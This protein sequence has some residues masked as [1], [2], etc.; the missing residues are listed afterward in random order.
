M[1]R[2]NLPLRVAG[3]TVLLSL[4][5]LGLCGAGA[6]YLYSQQATSADVLGENVSSAQAAHDLEIT[7]HGLAAL[8]PDNRRN[9]EGLNQLVINQITTAR[10]LADKEEERRL[11]G[12]LDEILH[13]Y[14]AFWKPGSRPTRAEAQSARDILDK[15]ALPICSKLEEFNAQQIKE[16]AA[17]HRATVRWMVAGLVGIGTV[18]SIGGLFLGY[19]VASSLRRSIYQLS[20]RVRD[21][22]GKL[23]QDLTPVVVTDDGDLHHL[24]NQVQGIMK[25]IEQVVAK[26]QQR[27]HEVLRAEQLAAVGQLAAG[28]AH[29]LRNPLTSVKILVQSLGE[30]LAGRGLSV[31]DLQIME[32]EIRRME[33]CLQAF[34]DF[35]R[36]PRPECRPLNLAQI[37]DRTFALIGSRARK[38]QVALKAA[39]PDFAV[40][41][42][43]D[44]DQI[45]Q[46]LVNLTLN[47]L[48]AMPHGGVLEVEVRPP[49]MGHVE[50][51]VRDTGPGIAA[52]VKDRLFA[53]FVSSK[54]TGLGLGLCTSRR[55]AEN[56][57]GTLDV[58]H[59]TQGGACFVLRLPVA[60][61]LAAPVAAA[62]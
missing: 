5:L 43:V 56:H 18:G 30:D 41:V 55:I 54:E 50:M 53:P 36:P 52:E 23:G 17:A 14:L 46:V 32:V 10:F 15:E 39:Q 60:A 22:A 59:E 4:L 51:H 35:A 2:N 47:A 27:E 13:R 58:G 29:E 9:I 24:H 8:L 57:G 45:H 37:V 16:S 11:V 44:G 33:R 62:G 25:E 28:M 12:D 3:P 61:P 7:L 42:N 26:L 19:T 40:I 31:D 34:L 1:W 6:A 49:S 48:D 20:V 21:A 38:Q